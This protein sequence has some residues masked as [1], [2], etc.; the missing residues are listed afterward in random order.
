MLPAHAD[1]L[2]A[3]ELNRP[4]VV[5]AGAFTLR[6]EAPNWLNGLRP[7]IAALSPPFLEL[8]PRLHVVGR[9]STMT[10]SFAVR[11][12]DERRHQLAKQHGLG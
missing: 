8:L 2:R 12:P 7:E 11:L 10:P 5:N 6:Y 1:V 4:T 3:L 9:A